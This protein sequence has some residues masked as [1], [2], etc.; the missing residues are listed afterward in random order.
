MELSVDEDYLDFA[1][2]LDD[3]IANNKIEEYRRR[4]SERYLDILN[5]VSKEMGE[6]TKHESDVEKIIRDINSDFKERNFAGVIKLIAL[7]SV[8]SAD[9]MVQL[10][11]RIKEFNDE[12]NMQWANSI[13]SRRQIAKIRIKRQWHICSTL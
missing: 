7:R 6:L 4:T 9:K 8:P 1:N 10:M 12:T 2:N 3:F 5:R 13:S 11:K